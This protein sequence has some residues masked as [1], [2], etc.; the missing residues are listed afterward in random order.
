MNAEKSRVMMGAEFTHFAVRAVADDG[1]T[2]ATYLEDAEQSFRESRRRR[3]ERRRMRPPGSG[4][5]PLLRRT[6]HDEVIDPSDAEDIFP[7][8]FLISLRRPPG[9]MGA[10]DF[11]DLE[12]EFDGGNGAFDSSREAAHV[13]YVDEKQG[14]DDCRLL[15][16][17]DAFVL[18]GAVK[19]YREDEGGCTFRHHTMLVHETMRTAGHRETAERIQQLWARAGYYSSSSHHRLN[20]LFDKDILSV[21]SWRS[22]TEYLRL[23]PS[24]SCCRTSR[25][26]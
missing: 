18:A 26:S 12:N 10:S 21:A 6:I 17:M 11:H 24:K 16:A 20:T 7:K 15:E 19:L 13:R 9:Y 4:F 1:T 25:R 14:E 5:A 3:R 2:F 23:V 8:D 22:A